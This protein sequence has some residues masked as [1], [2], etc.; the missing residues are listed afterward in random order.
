VPYGPA[1]MKTQCKL[2]PIFLLLG[3][4]LGCSG[5]DGDS[6]GG[7]SGGSTEGGG[8]SG[9]NGEPEGSGG[10]TGLE[11]CPGSIIATWEA[12]GESSASSSATYTAS[13]TWSLTLVDCK[14]D[15]ITEVLVFGNIPLP[16]AVGTY[17]LTSTLLHGAQ[18]TGEPGAFYSV[19][20]GSEDDSS[21]FTTTAESGELVVTEVDADATTLSGTFSFSGINDSGTKTVQVTGEITEAEFSM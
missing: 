17:V 12:E 3:A 5:G 15:D 7:G 19:D 1:I 13:G 21:Y 18:T 20:D 14:D 9:G 2:V 6:E 4:V 8:G 10:G 11:N 16:V